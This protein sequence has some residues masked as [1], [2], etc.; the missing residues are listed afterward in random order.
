MTT[1]FKKIFL[2]L[3]DWVLLYLALFLALFLRTGQ[4][5]PTNVWEIHWAVFTMV[6]CVWMLVFYLHGLYD[7][8]QTKNNYSFF[9]NFLMGLGVNLLL[10]VGY[11][12]IVNL[13]NLSPKTIL[14]IL[15]AVYIPLFVIWRIFSHWFFKLSTLRTRLVF[16]GLTEESLELINSFN[17]NPQIGYKTLL[18][19]T[20]ENNTLLKDLPVGITVLHTTDGLVEYLKTKKIDNIIVSDSKIE[21]NTE[22][23]LYSALLKRV[24]VLNLDSFFENI[25]HRVPLSALSEGWFLNN[26]S[27]PEKKSYEVVKRFADIILASFMGI[28]FLIFFIPLALLI[29][30]T[31]RGSIFYKQKR[32][33]L[34]GELF[35][36]YKFRSMIENAEN[37]GP[38]FASIG[39]TR[40]TKIGQI[41]RLLRLDELPQALNILRNEMSFIGPRPERPE[42]VEKLK[43]IMPYYNVR[44][45]I[46][47]GLTGW[48]QVNYSY[49]DS[50]EG[51]LIKLQ[52]D[53]FYIKNQSF[54]LD[55]ITLLKTI[56]AILGRK[57]R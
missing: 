24:N 54:L 31:D 33:G 6:F 27:Q 49:T 22:K 11:F 19:V 12:Y 14:L 42:F 35:T 29:Y 4:I 18:I 21:K 50:L 32:V 5:P 43:E 2:F 56:N 25:T 53:L 48:A 30:L 28:F 40:I 17:N 39:D 47:P 16:L 36:I 13:S 3:G 44:H 7:L 52:Y 23:I 38:Q 8:H 55:L 26:L 15:S 46:K 41:L 1:K 37:K 34:D 51:N 9:Q 10:T 57:G 45:L 20:D